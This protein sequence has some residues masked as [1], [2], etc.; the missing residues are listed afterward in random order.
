MHAFSN[1]SNPGDGVR[2]T[3]RMKILEANWNFWKPVLEK[4][5]FASLKV[6]Q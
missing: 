2:T 1:D 3:V 5:H 6:F 4:L